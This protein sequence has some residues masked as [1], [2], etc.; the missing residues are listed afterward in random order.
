MEDGGRRDLVKSGTESSTLQWSGDL[1][2]A[3]ETDRET[4]AETA[5]DDRTSVRSDVASVTESERELL[6]NSE[7]SRGGG[8]NDKTALVAPLE[9]EEE[10]GENQLPENAA[11]V[12]T[13]AGSA[14]C[15]S[16]SSARE[17]REFWE[18]ESQNGPL[19]VPQGMAHNYKHHQYQF[20]CDEAT[21]ST[22]CTCMLWFVCGG[23]GTDHRWVGL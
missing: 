2:R 23:Q 5:K 13:P 9:K 22:T 8:A 15:P 18:M 19:L 10:P 20:E 17:N 14:L 11:Q 1:Q 6:V 12:F 3:A 7:K 16:P 4:A 21:P